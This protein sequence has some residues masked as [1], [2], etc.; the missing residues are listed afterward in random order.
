MVLLAGAGKCRRRGRGGC[1]GRL[2][3]LHSR[4]QTG[5]GGRDPSIALV[6]LGLF[7]QLKQGKN[8]FSEGIERKKQ[9]KLIEL[10]LNSKL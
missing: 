1:L 5:R 7:V 3:D 2:R 9:T 10:S 8:M 6:A 4:V